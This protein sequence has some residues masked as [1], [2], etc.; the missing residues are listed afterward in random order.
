MYQWIS[1][2]SIWADALTKEMEIYDNM[3]ILLMEGLFVLQDL[4]INKV[5][6]LDGEIRML[7]IRNREKSEMKPTKHTDILA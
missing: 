7:N 5:Q 3:R 6:C 1:T 4:R 2:D